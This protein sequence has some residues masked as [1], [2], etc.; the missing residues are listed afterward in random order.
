[1]SRLV[2]AAV[3]SI[4]FAPVAFAQSQ[5]GPHVIVTTGQASIEMAPDIAWVAIA[6]EFRASTPEAAQKGS[7]EAMTAVQAALTRVGIARADVRTT[8]YSVQPDVERSGGRTR[9]I[10]YIARNQI[11]V[12][13]LD[14]GRLGAVIDAAGSTGATSMAGLRFDLADRATVE[15]DALRRAVEDAMARARAMADGAKVTLGSIVRID[16]QAQFRPVYA[17]EM[18]MQAAEAP[19]T[20]ISPGEIQVSAQVTLTV[21]IIK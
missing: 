13:V 5:Q 10:G 14:L 9:V 11:D 15:R 17:R 7:A 19:A 1:M 4:L 21:Q 18:Q 20:P 16:E 3:L 6:A 8:G 2:H 12:R